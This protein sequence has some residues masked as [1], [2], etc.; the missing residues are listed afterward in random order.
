MM[1]GGGWEGCPSGWVR[2]NSNTQGE[3]SLRSGSV[4]PS[5]CIALAQQAGCHI[6]NLNEGQSSCW[7]QY[8]PPVECDGGGWISC[9]LPP[10]SPL[11][12]SPP[13]APPRLPS[14]YTAHLQPLSWAEAEAS[15][16]A[17]GGTLAN[18]LS[19]AANAEVSAAFA[20]SSG[21][22][23]FWLGASDSGSEGVW[24][25]TASGTLPPT[26]GAEHEVPHTT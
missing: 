10:A 17:G 12:P 4:S 26:V 13:P 22:Y 19:A 5:D 2:S 14:P 16:Q 8:N 25:W 15:C 18:V 3:Y 1:T 9:V 23:A 24:R 21:V 11:P 6:A 20:G 7:C